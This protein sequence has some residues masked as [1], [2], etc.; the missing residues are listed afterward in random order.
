MNGG[1]IIGVLLQ[2][3][4]EASNHGIIENG[5]SSDSCLAVLSIMVDLCTTDQQNSKTG[6]QVAKSVE[7]TPAPFI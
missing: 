7:L 2:I 5:I 6:L 3:R 4:H 1:D